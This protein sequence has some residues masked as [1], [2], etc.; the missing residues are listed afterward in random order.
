MLTVL[1]CPRR[2][3][4]IVANVTR[5][6]GGGPSFRLWLA[7]LAVCA[8]AV[9]CDLEASTHWAVKARAGFLIL[10]MPWMT[11]I[12][13]RGWACFCKHG[14]RR[15]VAIA[16]QAGKIANCGLLAPHSRSI[17]WRSEWI[18]EMVRKSQVWNSAVAHVHVLS[19]SLSWTGRKQK[20]SKEAVHLCPTQRVV[21]FKV[22]RVK[23]VTI[24]QFVLHLTPLL[25][26]K[27]KLS[28]F[29]LCR[30]FHQHQWALFWFGHQKLFEWVLWPWPCVVYL[31]RRFNGWTIRKLLRIPVPLPY[32]K[33]TK[34]CLNGASRSCLFLQEVAWRRH[35]HWKGPQG[36]CLQRKKCQR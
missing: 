33:G 36:V 23:K 10:E 1:D 2:I 24:H 21:F 6:T 4:S 9:L 22:K 5:C 3:L 11:S 15:A 26:F 13:C 7:S 17:N 8:R 12:L 20:N 19:F 18:G 29:L 25:K 34:E 31:S 32:S 27:F 16:K 14:C 30:K 35:Q 28:S